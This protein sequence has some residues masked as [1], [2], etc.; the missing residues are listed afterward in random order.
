M[1]SDEDVG[2]RKRRR[3]DLEYRADVFDC[4]STSHLED[5]ILNVT[6]DMGADSECG[7]DREADDVIDTTRTQSCLR[8][9]TPYTSDTEENTPTTSRTTGRPRTLTT[10][11][12]S[13]DEDSDDDIV[14]DSEAD[15]NLDS[16]PE[17][18]RLFR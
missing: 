6:D 1:S 14:D 7:G 2:R 9:S 16:Q 15:P 10:Y 5:F 11:H 8:T 17:G 12:D 3:E 18:C 13:N 4:L